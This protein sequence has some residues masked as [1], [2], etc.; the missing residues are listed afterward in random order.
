MKYTQIPVNTFEEL[1]MNAGILVD[2]FSPDTGEITGSI[3][4]A[5][6]GGFQVSTNPTYT[7]FGEDID[8]IPANTMQMKRIT[9]YD[10]AIS[11]T[12]LTVTP[13][14]AQKLV[15]SA[16]V[17]DAH[18][19]PINELTEEDF[20]DVWVIGDYSNKNTGASA[21]FVAVRLINALNT[22]GFQWQ[23]TKDGKGQF[24]FDFHGHYDINDIDLVPFEIYVKAGET[25]ELGSITVSSG[26]TGVTNVGETKIQMSNYTPG[27][28]EK[29]V[30]KTA[31]STA[32]SVIY[33][34][35]L[36]SDWTLIQNGS[37][38]RPASGHTK[39]T[40]ASVDARFRAVASGEATLTIKTAT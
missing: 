8:N 17:D 15:G 2:E 39:I 38:I 13:E 32:P 31:V 20:A 9:A 16:V 18:I 6:T 35:K 25:P 11:G 12:F 24:A 34:Q 37:I 4:G 26:I 14:L 21:G 28:G 23:T 27:S 5:T 29:Y 40:V 10:P 36:T 33:G 7:D 19:I 1:Q 3:L 22:A 30:Y